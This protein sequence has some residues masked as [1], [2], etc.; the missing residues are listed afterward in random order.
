MVHP[1]GTDLELGYDNRTI[2]YRFNYATG[3]G[4]LVHFT[5]W[6]DGVVS[7]AYDVTQIRAHF[8][9]G[10]PADL[11]FQLHV[12]LGGGAA[13]GTEVLDQ[14]VTV[15][16][17]ETGEAIWKDINVTDPDL[18][19][20]TQDFW[21]WFEVTNTDP[22]DRYP[23]VLGDDEQPWDDVHNYV[24]PGTGNPTESAFFYQIHAVIDAGTPAGDLPAELP[25]VWNL[26][27]NYPNPFNPATEIRY[28]VP[29]TERM[30]LKV[31]N[32]MG[33][34]VATLVNGLVNAGSYVAAFDATDLPSGVYVYRLESESFTA[35]HKMLLLK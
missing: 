24:W 32:V 22:N 31:F 21:V 30:T 34:E 2:Q 13:P 27:Q 16:T 20:I 28:T 17:S 33:Q 5:P 1:A 4:A 14:A 25:L 6:T 26:E 11:P 3:Q 18:Q 10:Q 15:L 8:D 35:S 23:Q 29:N 19:N 12:Y 9:A 7:A